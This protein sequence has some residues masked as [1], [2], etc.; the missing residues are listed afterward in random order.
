MK[1]SEVF[2]KNNPNLG[3]PHFSSHQL[4][5]KCAVEGIA[6]T[7]RLANEVGRRARKGPSPPRFQ[8]KLMAAY[9]TTDFICKSSEICRSMLR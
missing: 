5:V 9:T 3:K 1:T 8:Q 4:E 2:K 6:V 7:S